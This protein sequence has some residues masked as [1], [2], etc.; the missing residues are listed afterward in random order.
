MRAPVQRI[1]PVRGLTLPPELMRSAP[2]DVRLTR[3]GRALVAVAWLL[4]IGGMTSGVLLY[5][6]A[7]RQAAASAAFDR[8]AVSTT[9]I[10]DL[11]WR[12]KGDG[13]PAYARFHFSVNGRRV[14]GEARMRTSVWRELHAGAPLPLRYLPD[15]PNRWAIDGARDRGLPV[16]VAYVVASI[17]S[18]ASLLCI[19]AVRRQ[20]VLLSE[21]RVTS[22]RI[23]SV[24]KQHGSHG[25]THHEIRYEFPLLSGRMAAGKA[26]ASKTAGV[27]GSIIVLYDPDR[28]A[29]N[30]PYPF[31]LVTPFT[32]S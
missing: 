6:E 26:S 1:D 18:V 14:N 30:Q 10:V 28:P 4:A 12:K 5:R 8:G 29:R 21:G 11:L 24:K 19:A 25:A 15:D 32:S 17:P 16:G 20:R 7:R 22:G 9:A 2:R 13:D 3:G 27:G 31:S 23:T